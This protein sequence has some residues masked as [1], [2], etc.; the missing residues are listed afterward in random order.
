MR[1]KKKLEPIEVLEVQMVEMC[2]WEVEMAYTT[3]R[4]LVFQF[5]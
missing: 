3:E 2:F 1:K 4:H 5:I